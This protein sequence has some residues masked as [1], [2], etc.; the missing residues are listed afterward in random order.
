MRQLGSY[1]NQNKE[2][3]KGLNVLRT[4]ASLA[5]VQEDI[6]AITGEMADVFAALY[7]DDEADLDQAVEIAAAVA[8]ETRPWQ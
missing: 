5:K 4:A 7:V 8:D 2:Y 6:D 3:A 1:Y